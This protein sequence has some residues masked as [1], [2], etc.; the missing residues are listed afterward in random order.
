MYRIF[1][2]WRSIQNADATS[3]G[4]SLIPDLMLM[5][6]KQMAAALCPFILEV[7]KQNGTN[8][9]S[10]TLYEIVISLQLYMAMYGHEWKLLDDLEFIKVKNTLD[11]RMKELAN[12]GFVAPRIQAEEIG[13]DKEDY[14]WKQGVL[15]ES[16]PRQLVN[17][18]LYMI[19]IHFALRA[20]AEHRNLRLGVNSQ[21]AYH[22]DD[23][24]GKRY[25][26]YTEDSSKNNQGGINQRKVKRKCV[27]AYENTANPQR[28][29]VR[30]FNK[31]MMLRPAGV[32]D[33]YLRPLNSPK[34]DCW[35]SCQPIGRQTLG[36]VVNS[37]LGKV[38]SSGKI[39]NH[40]LRATAASRLYQH[41]VDEQLIQERTGHCSDSVR[42]YKRTDS[43][44]LHE[45]SEILYG[46]EAEAPPPKRRKMETEE[47]VQVDDSAENCS[48]TKNS[49]LSFNF[50]INVNK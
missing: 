17:T 30:L 28:C 43:K 38:G 19:G 2:D 40:S 44:Q 41:N 31:Y 25:L 6:K 22:Y 14:L 13:I 47:C 10:Q 18:L 8:Y 11:N 35:F 39:T 49:K 20:G 26:Q 15:G 32:T 29:L 36:K 1:T 23:Q 7:R 5:D 9:P 45:I 48:D 34:P 16:T 4:K 21:F 27:R 37:L 46:N 12:L 50:T 42:S 33:F 24:V 3:K